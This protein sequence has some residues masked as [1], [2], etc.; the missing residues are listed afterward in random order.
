MLL[1]SKNIWAFTKIPIHGNISEDE[2]KALSPIVG[3]ALP[4]MAISKIKTDE[5]G[6]PTRAK[7]RRVVLGNLDPHDWNQKDC[8][9]PVISSLELR[10]L[11][12]ICTQLRCTPKSGDV[13]RAFVQSILPANEKYIVRPPHGCSI[14]PSKTYLLLKKTL[15]RLKRSPRHWYETCKK[16]LIDLGLQPCPNAPCIFTGTLIEGQPPLFL[17]LFVDDFIYFSESREV[18]QQFESPFRRKFKVDFQNEI[19]H[20]LGLKFTT[21]RHTDGNIDIYESTKRC[22]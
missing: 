3:N 12:F 7:Y 2:Y 5:N 20:F 6:N 22:Q 4:T 16:T 13:S 21:V 18:E 1:I 15:Y 10:L 19:S 9:A 8:F 14:T 17:G 11:V